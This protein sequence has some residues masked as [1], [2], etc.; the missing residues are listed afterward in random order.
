M[1]R[2]MLVTAVAAALTLSRVATGSPISV[3][4][5]GLKFV[6]ERSTSIATTFAVA[7]TPTGTG[8]AGLKPGVCGPSASVTGAGVSCSSSDFFAHPVPPPTGNDV[9]LATAFGASWRLGSGGTADASATALKGD[10]A[11]AGAYARGGAAASA[12]KGSL[13]DT[14][15]TKASASFS[16]GGL[17]I[18]GSKDPGLSFFGFVISDQDPTILNST[19]LSEQVLGLSLDSYLSD[20]LPAGFSTG[21]PAHVFWGLFVNL[22]GGTGTLDVRNFGL[23]VTTPLTAADFADASTATDVVK[24]LQGSGNFT[25]DIPFLDLSASSQVITFDE[26]AIATASASAPEPSTVG[27]LLLAAPLL[28]IISR[29]RAT[30]PRGRVAS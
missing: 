22:D 4:L 26:V 17:T 10:F 28:V 24:T 27:T 29:F 6:V 2:M 3:A 1:S 8:G 19:L 23:S 16:L 20:D 9:A 7:H 30:I 15:L 5:D 11:A 21:V 12:I 18:T 14:G 25:I 13:A